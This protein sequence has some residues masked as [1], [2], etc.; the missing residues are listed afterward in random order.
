VADFGCEEKEKVEMA[1]RRGFWLVA[2][3]SPFSISLGSLFSE[4]L[5]KPLNEIHV[6][7]E[8]GQDDG[9]IFIPHEEDVMV[10]ATV[11]E[12]ICEAF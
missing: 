8:D 6:F 3:D 1:G 4:T 9:N 11:D 2:W 10:L 7:V 12:R 5:A